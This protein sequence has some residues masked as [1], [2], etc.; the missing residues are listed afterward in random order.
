MRE[1]YLQIKATSGFLHFTFITGISKFNKVD[2]FSSLNNIK[3]ISLN[4]KFSCMMGYTHEELMT[5]FKPYFK[6]LAENT[7]IAEVDL[8]KKIKE[9]Y[10]GF[11]FDGVT[12]VYNPLSILSLFKRGKFDNFWME[13]GSTLLIREFFKDKKCCQRRTDETTTSPIVY[14]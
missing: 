14:F 12:R 6:S 2:I 9:Y 3:D 11:S 7:G 5:Y 13:S 10:N 1:F 8:P 4:P